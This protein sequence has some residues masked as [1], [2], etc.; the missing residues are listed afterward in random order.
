MNEG[1]TKKVKRIWSLPKPGIAAIALVL[2]VAV[3]RC[4]VSLRSGEADRKDAGVISAG[5]VETCRAER[6]EAAEELEMLGQ[7]IFREKVAVASKVE[8]R[9]AGIRVNAGDRVAAGSLI[10]EIE[11]LPLEIQ[12]KQQEAELDIARKAF[13]L[14]RAKYENALK[15]VE[16]KF[17][18]IQKARADLNDK[19]VSFENMDR[20]LKNRQKLF[21]AGGVSESEL[22]TMKAQHTTVHTSLLNT[23]AD[24]EIQLVGFRDEDIVSAGYALPQGERD[25]IELLKKIN[26]RIEYAEL[27]S[28]QSRIRLAENNV[29]ATGLMLR[30]TV[31]RSPINGIV[32]SKNM[33]AGEMIRS[34]SVIA[35]V[36]NIDRVY[37]AVN[38]NE[39][40]LKKLKQGQKVDFTVDALGDRAF[41]ARIARISPVL[42][43]KTRTVEVKAETANPGMALVPGMF[44]RAKIRVGSPEKRLM[45]PRSSLISVIGTEGE[46][47]LVKKGIAF[48][49]RVSLGTE[50]GSEIE[51]LRGIEENDTVVAEGVH[52]VYPGMVVP[53]RAGTTSP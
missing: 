9:I 42:D 17:K 4:A 27:E 40:D 7:I 41:E 26:T 52:T 16:V 28:A 51:V 13:D 31:I 32:A 29:K 15:A 21:E 8:G 30:E 6:K 35:V 19:K 53:A 39:K 23:G 38:V 2:L 1:V 14:A 49:Q 36:M 20:V 11:R 25:K 46:L 48:R 12:L 24:L 18:M 10:A 5:D 22:R 45:V 44:A 37:V 34:D 47:Y 33:E 50:F 43:V 3:V